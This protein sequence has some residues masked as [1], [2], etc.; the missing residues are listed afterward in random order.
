VEVAFLY[1]ARDDKP[2]KKSFKKN[3]IQP[4]DQ[5]LKIIDLL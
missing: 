2:Y 1:A 3:K 4:I 5:F